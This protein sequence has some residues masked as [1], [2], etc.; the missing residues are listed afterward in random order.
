MVAKKREEWHVKMREN[1]KLKAEGK[2]YDPEY[3]MK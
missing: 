3:V 2:E 1:T